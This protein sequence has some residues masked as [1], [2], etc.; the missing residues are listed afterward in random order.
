MLVMIGVAAAIAAPAR[1]GWAQTTRS[2]DSA[3]ALAKRVLQTTP[4]IDGHNDLPWRIREDSIHPMDVVA[5]NLRQTTP[6]QTDLARLKQGMVG[7]QFWSVYIPGEPGGKTYA[8]NGT[9]TSEPGYARVQLEQIDIALRMIALYPDRLTLAT[10]AADIRQD[11]KNGHIASMLGMEG[12]HAIENS[13][14]RSA[15]TTR[16][17]SAT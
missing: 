15:P 11:F 6:G 12:G 10:S 9:V 14:G 5:Y 2:A 13:L 7:G 16:S 3:A 17:A 8:V 1:E 4:L